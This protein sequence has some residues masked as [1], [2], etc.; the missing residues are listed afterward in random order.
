MREAATVRMRTIA[1]TRLLAPID[2]QTAASQRN[3]SAARP[4][5][6]V[7][8]VA[9]VAVRTHRPRSNLSVSFAATARRLVSSLPWVQSI[10]TRWVTPRITPTPHPATARSSCPNLASTLWPASHNTWWDR[11]ANPP[12]CLPIRANCRSCDS[13]RRGLAKARTSTSVKIV[14]TVSPMA[15]A[16]IAHPTP[17]QRI[18]S[19]LCVWCITRASSEARPRPIPLW[20]RSNSELCM[21]HVSRVNSIHLRFRNSPLRLQPTQSISVVN[22]PIID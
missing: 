19:T 20:I 7:E 11:P 8:R 1:A 15:T 21:P 4:R 6:S 14:W 2:R 5:R 13:W 12:K 9:A 3:T 16:A 10:R 17:P 22:P 18:L